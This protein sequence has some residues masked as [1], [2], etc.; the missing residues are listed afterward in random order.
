MIS[1][2]HQIVEDLKL[3]LDTE[4]GDVDDEH[5]TEVQMLIAD[6]LHRINESLELD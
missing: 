6:S 4:N 1:I 2:I 5:L 3:L